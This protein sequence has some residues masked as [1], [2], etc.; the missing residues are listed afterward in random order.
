MF[1]KMFLMII[2]LFCFFNF[3][4]LTFYDVSANQI[5]P[6]K[7]L[8]P[9]DIQTN[10]TIMSDWYFSGLIGTQCVVEI[11]EKQPYQTGYKL[12][13]LCTEYYDTKIIKSMEY[14]ITEG[15][16]STE[17]IS[18]STQVSTS[19]SNLLKVGAGIKS[20]DNVEISYGKS[21][22]FGVQVSQSFQTVYSSQY[23]TSQSYKYLFDM[24][25]VDKTKE[26]FSLGYVVQCV[27]FHVKASYL[28]QNLMFRG[29][30]KLDD[31]AKYDYDAYVYTYMYKTWI[32]DNGKYFG[33]KDN[34]RKFDL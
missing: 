32:Y 18:T 16:T 7:D 10:K 15:F 30:T 3:T 11:D 1:K 5:V 6:I 23:S 28:A 25:T 14:E 8:K 27:V 17:S 4:S 13:A 2:I 29:F 34:I 26:S 24:D 22:E 12:G 21:H 33:T 19:V 9:S 20:L 31:T